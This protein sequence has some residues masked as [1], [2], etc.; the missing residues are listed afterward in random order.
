M[1]RWLLG[2]VAQ[3]V[4]NEAPCSVRIVRGSIGKLGAP[5]CLVIGVDGT[6]AADAAVRAMAQRRWP[7]G[8][9]ARIVSV[10]DWGGVWLPPSSDLSSVFWAEVQQRQMRWLTQLANQASRDLQRSGLAVR[11]V[12]KRGDAKQVLAQEA[13]RWDA[14]C[15]VVGATGVRGLTRLLMGS[16]ATAITLR[17]VCSVEVV[18]PFQRISRVRAMGRS[19]AKRSTILI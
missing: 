10:V 8:S 15:L 14:D 17:A 16:V 4:L 13:E 12:V 5:V 18:R 1:A 11:A 6:A 3:Q 19:E 9:T 7:R 2:S